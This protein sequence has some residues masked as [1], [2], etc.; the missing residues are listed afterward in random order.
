MRA[1][2]AALT[3]ARHSQ[4]FVMRGE[5]SRAETPYFVIR[6]LVRDLVFALAAAGL[7]MPGYVN[8]GRTLAGT[9]EDRAKR[10]RRSG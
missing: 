2:D 5:Q 4:V 10:R 9:T 8:V 3:T 7:G 6:S 1:D